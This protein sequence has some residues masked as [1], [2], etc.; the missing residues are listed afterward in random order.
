MDESPRPGYTLCKGCSKEILWAIDDNGTKHP[1]D[2]TPPTYVVIE[3]A[4]KKGAFR[5]VRSMA[6]V[7]HFATCPLANT[8][9]KRNKPKEDGLL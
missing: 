6:Y 8:F 5:A 4:K 7:S 2:T 9:S 1:L 3:D